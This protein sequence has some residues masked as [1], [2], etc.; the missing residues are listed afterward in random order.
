MELEATD[1]YGVVLVTAT[2]Q[3]EA[4]AIAEALITA[5]LAACVSFTPIH[6][7]YTWQGQVHKDQ[8][9][10][11]FIKTD[12]AQF[13]ALVAKVQEVHSYDVPE[14]I[15]LPIVAGSPAYLQWLGEQVRR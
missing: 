6:S 5:K 9:W 12:L 15:A 3:V 8:E 10:Q 14:I 1:G 2:S 7:I 11:L 13:A 4:E